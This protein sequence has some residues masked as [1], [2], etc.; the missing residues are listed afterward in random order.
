MK[1]TIHNDSIIK[2]DEERKELKNIIEKQASR[3]DHF[4]SGYPKELVLNLYFS[5]AAKDYILITAVIR[6]KNRT[7][8][9]KQSGD[10][11]ESSVYALFDRLKLT[12]NKQLHKLRNEHSR[13]AKNIRIR[14]FSENLPELVDLKNEDSDDLLKDILKLLLN[15]IAP[16]THRRLKTA[17]RTS[18]V[19]KG[20]FKTPELLDEIYLV[21]YERLEEVPTDENGIFAWLHR[22]VDEYLAEKFQEQEF[23][24][25]HFE[26]INNILETE[27]QSLEEEYTIDADYDIVPV[28]ELDEYEAPHPFYSVNQLEYGIDEHYLLD[29]LIM[30]L[31]DKDI[32][33]IIDKELIKLP[34]LR[35]TIMD[36]YLLE[37]MTAEEIAHVK[38]I[39][40]EEVETVIDEVN[41]HLKEKLSF[42]AE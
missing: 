35:R 40:V 16:Y 27:V 28:E 39:S 30:K 5:K 2:Q 34:V 23:E 20:M 33:D 12:L 8:L 21:I 7:L 10:N 14:S 41:C 3:L 15:D 26:S 31:N 17:E 9:V 18:S 11:I 4:A 32:H 25:T 29:D 38:S 24:N 22:I 36:L 42:L 6:L 19:K 1:Y 37:Q 13:H